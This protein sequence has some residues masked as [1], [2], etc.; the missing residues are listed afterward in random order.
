[1]KTDEY[2]VK[3]SNNGK[4]LYEF[5]NDLEGEYIIPEGVKEI[6][7]YAL[8]CRPSNVYP[9]LSSLRISKT[10]VKIGHSSGYKWLDSISI[11]KDN[12]VYDSREDCKAIIETKSNTLLYGCKHAFVPNGVKKINMQAFDNAY[13]ESKLFIPASVEEI[14]AMSFWLTSVDYIEVDA[15]NKFY[16]SRENCNAI[17]DS[18][19][20][21][22]VLGSSHTFIPLGIESIGKGAFENC[23]DIQRLVIPESVYNFKERAFS[24]AEIEELYISKSVEQIEPSAFDGCFIR[25]IFVDEN[26]TTFYEQGNCLI[27]KDTARLRIAGKNFTIPHEVKIIGSCS[28]TLSEDGLLEIPDG[29][30]EIMSSAIS[31]EGVRLRLVLPSSVKMIMT[32]FLLEKDIEEIV[33]PAGQKER[34]SRMDGLKHFCHLIIEANE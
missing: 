14:D 25:E 30:V 15:A 22:L 13:A 17:I 9:K 20:N 29:V 23:H 16:D 8:D 6:K 12:P 28:L 32:Q 19:S 26:N 33:V 27:T 21:T 34:F 7:K 10:V 1:M 2:G 5:P 3:Y 18:R 4:I 31:V 11:D 24:Y